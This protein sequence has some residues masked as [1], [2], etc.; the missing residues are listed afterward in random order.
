MESLGELV[1]WLQSLLV[2]TVELLPFIDN[3]QA[4]ISKVSSWLSYGAL[5]GGLA[6]IPM[7]QILVARYTIRYAKRILRKVVKWIIIIG[8]IGFILKF[9]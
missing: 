9:L 6:T 4:F 7:Y 2:Q 1:Q 3:G 5:G 8:V